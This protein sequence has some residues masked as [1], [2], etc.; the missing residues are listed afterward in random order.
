MLASYVKSLF[1]SQYADRNTIECDVLTKH[2]NFQ[3][4][5]RL[6]PNIHD[7]YLCSLQVVLIDEENPYVPSKDFVAPIFHDKNAPFVY[8]S[9]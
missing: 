4:H 5:V 3:L 7:K 9:T 1:V 8:K 6:V 2:K